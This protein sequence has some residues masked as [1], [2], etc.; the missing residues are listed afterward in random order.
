[1]TQPPRK[2]KHVLLV[3][4]DFPPVG[5]IGVQRALK[6]AQYLGTFGWQVTV[7]TAK[8]VYSATMDPS[9]AALIPEDVPVLRVSDPVSKWLGRWQHRLAGDRGANVVHGT[10]GRRSDDGATGA[11][12]DDRASGG[13]TTMTRTPNGQTGSLL[14][15]L[16]ARRAL[17][18]WKWAKARLLIPDEAMV[19]ALRAA[20]AGN[21]LIRQRGVDCIYTTSGPHSTHLA[22][23]IMKA[24]TGVPWVAD[25]R[26]PWTDNLHFHHSGLRARIERHLERMVLQRADAV[27]TV[28]DGFRRLF[29]QK[30]PGLRE[31]LHLIRNGVDEADF[32][33]PLYREPQDAARAREGKPRFVL[34]YAGILYPGRSPAAFLQAVHDLIQSGRVARQ[35]LLIQFAGVFDYPGHDDNRRL[36][37][38]LGLTDVT[39]VLGY[40]PR[41]EALAR[42]M[43]ADVLLLF[44]DLSQQAGDYVPGKLYEY[45]YAGRPILALLPEGEAADI[46]RREKAGIV[47]D[48]RDPAAIAD[49]LLRILDLAAHGGSTPPRR[50]LADVYTRRGQAAALA[51]CMDALLNVRAVP[52]QFRS[53][54]P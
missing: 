31:K 30:D 18:L 35:D 47:V 38:E 43:T 12:G 27:V 3:S 5:G 51:A 49:G 36:V 1:M 22:G 4:H 16:L 42:M 24:A 23:L 21:V 13:M 9:L 14:R 46:V 54:I 7:L 19:W 28:T 2:P 15:T 52:A 8:D 29:E 45:L 37:A 20:L 39:E 6:F 53:A 33:T 48:P 26:D 44:G 32:P 40:I 50:K 34:F 10:K 25:F 17:R 41:V 11:A